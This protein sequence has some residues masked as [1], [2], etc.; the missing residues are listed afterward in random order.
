ALRW[1]RGGGAAGLAA[2]APDR[3]SGDENL[4][5]TRR[6]A[7]DALEARGATRSAVERRTAA[8]P[9]GGGGARGDVGA[10]H[11]VDTR[12]RVSP[13]APRAHEPRAVAG[14][15]SSARRRRCDQG[16]P[17]R[18]RGGERRSSQSGGSGCEAAAAAGSSDRRLGE[19]QYAA[20]GAGD[21]VVEHNGSSDSTCSPEGAPAA[22]PPRRVRGESNRSATGRDGG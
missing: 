20:R 15:R 22:R 1:R 10:P 18:I 12:V 2:R 5:A 8:G 16:S 3:L 14:P 17:S 7:A 13:R 11:R 6:D 19:C 4:A 21:R 9:A